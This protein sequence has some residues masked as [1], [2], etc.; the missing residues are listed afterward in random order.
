MLSAEGLS[1]CVWRTRL[2]AGEAVRL[3]REC[4]D[5]AHN[6]SG[7]KLTTSTWLGA[8]LQ[9]VERELGWR[10]SS[11]DVGSAHRRYASGEGEDVDT[12]CACAVCAHELQEPPVCIFRHV[13]EVTVR[14]C[15]WR[16]FRCPSLESCT[17]TW[18]WAGKGENIKTCEC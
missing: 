15:E 5:P 4:W 3:S 17:Y 2:V 7:E 1:G 14:P 16:G 9:E 13:R 18:G 12:S 11:V 8:I 10:R 6:F